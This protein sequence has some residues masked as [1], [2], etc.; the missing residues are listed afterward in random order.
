MLQVK[1]NHRI[2][3]S[4]GQISSQRG[5]NTARVG[6][7]RAF[8]GVIEIVDD[9]EGREA[10]NSREKLYE[11]NYQYY[12]VLGFHEKSKAFSTASKIVRGIERTIEDKRA[13]EDASAKGRSS[14]SW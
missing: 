14:Y 12:R 5:T 10:A 11:L 2:G 1:A 6:A 3:A 13:S 9:A 7:F 8:A 4:L